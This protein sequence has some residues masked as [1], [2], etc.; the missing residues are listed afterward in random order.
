MKNETNQEEKKWPYDREPEESMRCFYNS[1]NEKDRRRYAG[2]E[3]LRIGHGGRGYLAEVWGCSR[4]TVSKG[5]CEVSSL[6]MSS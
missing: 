2:V 1:L 6:T 3:A 5:A 4:G